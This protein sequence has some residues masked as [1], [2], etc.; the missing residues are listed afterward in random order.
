MTPAP[1]P[2]DTSVI[3]GVNVPRSAV[4]KPV[5]E[6]IADTRTSDTVWVLVRS[7]SV[8]AIVPESV[9]GGA[10]FSVGDPSARSVT[11]PT[12]S[13]VAWLITGT[14]LVPVS[15]IVTVCVSVVFE[16]VLH[17][18]GIGLRDRLALGQIV[19]RA[20][21]NRIVPGMTPAPSPVDTLV[22]DGVNV[23]R[24]AVG[25]PVAELIADTR[26]SDTVW[27]LVRSTSVNAIVPELV[28]GGAVFSVGD[29]SAR[30]VTPPSAPP[31][32]G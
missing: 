5:A 18:D 10:V 8:N 13:A 26:T 29:P 9:K 32:R 21:R 17:R 12:A 28:K 14:S 1:S 22:I 30:S 19:E 24:S 23:P 11:P 6:S 20:R 25:K 7:T 16:R 15:V 27:V 4:G 3:D 2:V 31:S